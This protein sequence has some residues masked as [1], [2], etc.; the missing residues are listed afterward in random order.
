VGLP[1]ASTREQAYG[2][3][4]SPASIL[5]RRAGEGRLRVGKLALAVRGDRLFAA[6]QQVAGD[7]DGGMEVAARAQ[8]RADLAP[9]I[10][11]HRGG[12]ELAEIL[13]SPGTQPLLGPRGDLRAGPRGH[14]RRGDRRG[15]EPA[16]GR[17]RGEAAAGVEAD[18]H[19][20]D[21]RCGRGAVPVTA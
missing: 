19:A 18:D 11:V 17:R 12:V 8:H 9:L 15:L 6:Q 2:P 14:A 20:L 4:A 5:G 16:R 7:D 13:A 3:L 1:D 21:R 10:P